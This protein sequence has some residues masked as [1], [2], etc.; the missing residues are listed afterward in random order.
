MLYKV[1]LLG[2]PGNCVV[3]EYM[4]WALGVGVKLEIEVLLYVDGGVGVAANSEEGLLEYKDW[5]DGAVGG[6]GTLE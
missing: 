1:W 6:G 4:D 2:V 5:D 3:F